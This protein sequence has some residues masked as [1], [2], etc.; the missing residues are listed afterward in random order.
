MF[1]LPRLSL[2]QLAFAITAS[3]YSSLAHARLSADT[4]SMVPFLNPNVEVQEPYYDA[5]GLLPPAGSPTPVSLYS[6]EEDEY[7]VLAHHPLYPKYKVRVKKSRFCDETVKLRF[8]LFS[9]VLYHEIDALFFF[10]FSCFCF[11]FGAGCVLVGLRGTSISAPDTCF[12]TFSKAET[13]LIKTMSYFGLMA[14]PDVLPLSG[15]SS[16]SVSKQ[17]NTIDYFLYT[18]DNFFLLL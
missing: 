18:C 13:T 7:T 9:V 12:S 5:A 10:L 1:A 3:Y 2:L 15:S 14:A 11:C 8:F 6:L 17:V 4:P 16:N